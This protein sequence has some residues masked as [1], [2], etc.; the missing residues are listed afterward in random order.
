[1]QYFTTTQFQITLMSG[2]ATSPSSY[3]ISGLHTR[4][5]RRSLCTHIFIQFPTPCYG[6]TLCNQPIVDLTLLF[7]FELTFVLE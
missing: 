1:M 6:E 4:R 7:A 3:C 2:R 5:R